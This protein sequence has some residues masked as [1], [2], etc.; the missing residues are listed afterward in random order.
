M[1]IG[2]PYRELGRLDCAPLIQAALALSEDDWTARPIRRAS[3]A[4]GPHDTAQSIV[5]RHDWTPKASKRGFPTLPHSLVD[6]ARRNGRDPT[7]LLPVLEERFGYTWI[8]TFA[9]W[10]RW[11]DMLLPLILDV[12]GAIDP[13]PRGTLTRALFVRLPAGAV[14]APHVDGQDMAKRAHRIHVA[15]SHSPDCLYT[16]GDASFTMT[17]GTAYDFNNRWT[18]GVQNRGQTPR[19]NLMLEYLPD[20]GWIGPAPILHRPGDTR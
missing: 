7:P 19:I 12:V 6:W 10:Y 13:H 16:V 11:Q 18:H 8:Y 4:G 9:D 17:P 3:L 5:L 15:L 20:P 2:V 14:I 1:D